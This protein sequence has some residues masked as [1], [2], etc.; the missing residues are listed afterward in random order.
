MQ[1]KASYFP[2]LGFGLGLR[3]PHYAHIFEHFPQV[4]WFEI[5]SENF[6]DTDGKAKRNL[7]RI[8]ER[9]PI[10]MHGVSLSIGTVD[11]L[12]S[13]YLRKLKTLMNDVNPAWIS[14]HL[15]WTGIAHKN[16]HD[17]LPV[18]Y[19]EEA[20]KHII[21]RIKQVQDYLERPIALENPS[22]YLEFKSSHIPEAEFIATMAKESGCYLLLDVNNVYVTCYNHR[23][24]VKSY[25]D[26]LPLDKIV[27]I[28]L[29]GHSNRGSHIIDTHDDRVVDAVWALY[30]YTIHKAGRIINTMVEWDDKIPSWEVLYNE[31]EKAKTAAAN[32]Q[33]YAPLP[34]LLPLQP[35]SIANFPIPLRESQLSMQDAILLGNDFDSKPECWIRGK[36][37]FPAKEQL[38]VYINAY[39]YRLYDVTAEDYP[40]LK[41]YL[42]EEAFDTLIWDLVNKV[43][44][45]DF[46]ISRYAAHLPA[47]LAQHPSGDKIAC[48][49]A[50][51]EN[52]ISQ[53]CDPTETIALEPTHLAGITAESLMEM[54]LHPRIA[55][56][57]LAFDYP[58]NNYYLAVKEEL[59]TPLLIPQENFVV[60]FRH[61]D[62]VW[63][64]ELGKQEYY[65]LQ[66]LFSNIPIGDALD[67]LQTELD[68][69]EDA[70][71]AHLSEWF[72][73]WIRN[74]LLAYKK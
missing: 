36:E 63:R 50:I 18:P 62:V 14:D 74:G 51:L 72:S 33:H 11:P 31:L 21:S 15:C 28:H 49:L 19:T 26:A 3:I 17:L 7:A 25:I 39:R 69:P 45:T 1:Q 54:V 2:D 12:N 38:N 61:E 58:V 68:L 57:L 48:E 5:I 47:F 55:L 71:S 42:G 23:L 32:A 6:M 4:D 41:H 10:V 52:T 9:Y 43:A 67:T 44:S 30:K 70:L 56:Q 24:D 37:Q 40:V 64:M 34:D 60:V 13:E 29:S 66:K 59:P 27:Q 35:H 16:A 73:R 46:N 20:L 53:L 8:R 22:T 65:L